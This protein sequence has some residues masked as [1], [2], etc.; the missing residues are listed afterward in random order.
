[1][2]SCF[3]EECN[4]L[5]LQDQRKRENMDVGPTSHKSSGT[6]LVASYDQQNSF[7]VADE[8]CEFKKFFY[9]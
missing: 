6:L 1:M 8:K 4:L 7:I 9:W 3:V 5:N 2:S